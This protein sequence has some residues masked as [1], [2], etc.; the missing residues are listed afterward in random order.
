[1]KL[2][3]RIKNSIINIRKSIE[4]FPV[5]IL[6]STALALLL[7]YQREVFENLT[8]NQQEMLIRISMVVG[9][10]IP[11]S[12]TIGLLL[13]RFSRGKA[14]EIG[15]Y[16]I[17]GLLLV[18]YYFLLLKDLKMVPTTRFLATMIFL[19]ISVFYVLKLK[20]EINYEVYV[21]KM[22]FAGFLTLL[23]SGVLF[24]GIAAILGTIDG[25]FDVDIDGNYYYYTFLIVGFIFGVSMFLSKLPER[26]EEFLDYNYSKS[27]KVLLVYIVIP[28]ITIYTAILYAYFVKILVQ[29]E[30]P[31]GLVSH[32]VI[33]YSALSVGVI[34]LIT[35]VLEE[36]K[37]A[38]LFR[39]FFPIGNLPI[40]L[41]MYMSIYQ[42]IDQYGFTERRYYIVV[43]G[44]WI[45]AMM[46]YFIFTKSLRNIIIPISLSLVVFISVYGPISSYAISKSS[47][48]NRFNKILMENGMLENGVIIQNPDLDL[49]E[50][51][52]ISNII[53]YFI[54]NHSLES[55][56]VLPQD[57]EVGNMEDLFG[58]KYRDYVPIGENRAFFGYYAETYQQAIDIAGYD[59]SIMMSSWRNDSIKVGNLDLKYDSKTKSIIVREKDIELINLDI[60]ELA[61]Q[62]HDKNSGAEEFKSIQSLE[63]MTY[64]RENEKIR[65]KMVFTSINGN[66]DISTNEAQVENAEFILLLD[67]K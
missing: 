17:G 61:L 7:I 52:E 10:G 22:F 23:Y 49:S 56:K 32:L 34:F 13:E 53:N 21:I 38:K 48:N 33:W 9:L 5:T 14:F 50:Q 11:L 6:V 59:Y 64:I 1:M 42:R 37:V 26:D 8:S 41:M 67:R 28:L 44:L 45:T 51:R 36:N 54:Y 3:E 66:I 12:L 35:P 20:H 2:Q 57:F 19:I 40:L 31:R 15:A 39:T 30:W 27:L 18:G 43:L 4:R 62:V 29:W 63:D 24:G 46:L 55:L 60:N 58:F 16:I 65:L 47:Q 25:L